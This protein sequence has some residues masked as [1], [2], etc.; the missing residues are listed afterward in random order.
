MKRVVLYLRVSTEGQTTEN[1]RLAIHDYVSRQ[2]G[3]KVT[4]EYEDVGVSGAKHDR[5]GLDALKAD[6]A[7]RKF[8]AVVVWKFDRMARSVS[9]LLETL[10]LFQRYH[11]DFASVT[12]AVDTSTAAGRMLLTFLGA[13]GEFERSLTVE[14][15]RCGLARA[16][17]N[18]QALGRPRRGFD[19]GRALELRSQ[20]LG[21]KQVAKALGVPRTTLF[22]YLKAIPKPADT[23]LALTGIP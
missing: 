19:L 22:R 21:Y 10:A 18:G 13:V 2:D 16:K 23:V 7:K 11:I 15:V 3:W 12:E 1:Q 14:R 4:A 8:D 6:A 5:Q 20:G 9:H 17:A